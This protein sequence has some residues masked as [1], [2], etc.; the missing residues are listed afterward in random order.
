ME[1]SVGEWKAEVWLCHNEGDW[2]TGKVAV[3]WGI[4]Q[5]D[6]LSALLFYLTLVPLINTI[7]KEQRMKS[8]AKIKS[9]IYSVWMT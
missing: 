6:S 2:R 3:K 5:C 9:A 4:F 7:N 8:R 1:T